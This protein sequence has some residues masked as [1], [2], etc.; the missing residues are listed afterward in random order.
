MKR[1]LP[2]LLLSVGLVWGQA[3]VRELLESKTLSRIEEL[4]R[5]LDGAL[6]V[7]VIDLTTGRALTYHA[8]SVFPTASSIKVPIMIEVFRKA[9]AG[10]LPLDREIPL[11]PADLVDG[12]ARLKVMLRNGTAK[13]TVRELVEAMIEVSDNSATNKLI[14]LAGMDA[15]NH[16]LDELGLPNTRLR[17]KMMDWVDTDH[18]E[19][20]STPLEMARLMEALYRGKAAHEADTA[21][22]LKI[23][24]RVEAGMRQAVPSKIEVAAKPGEIP[25]VYCE[26]GIVFLPWRPFA[27]SVMSA[28]VPG[29][30]NPVP[31]VTAMIY[32]L[33]EKLDGANRYGHTL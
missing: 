28:F 23:L 12:S 11:A 27:L 1:L 17:R 24:K 18:R 32:K 21:E 6:G 22:M 25:G 30:R 5:A 31:E 7:A 4:D 3:D 15:V 13:A 10:A 33:F 29:G 19:N 14:D 9:R 26:T 16:T 20:I 8:D 2:G